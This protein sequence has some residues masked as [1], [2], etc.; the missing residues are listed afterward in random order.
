MNRTIQLAALLL[1]AATTV[2]AAAQTTATGPYYATPSWDQTMPAATRFV[3]LSNFNGEAV[4]DRE[5]G[6]VWAR[7]PNWQPVTSG[8][9]YWL[10][11]SI[12]CAGQSI[13]GRMGWR[14]ATAA[15]LGSLFD[16]AAPFPHLPV[17]HP[18]QLAS[19]NGL[20]AGGDGQAASTSLLWHTSTLVSDGIGG[21]ARQLVF[22][23][24][25]AVF[26][27]FPAMPYI[28]FYDNSNKSANGYG[29]ST[30]YIWCVR[31]PAVSPN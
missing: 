11:S 10:V 15:E 20:Y 26:A 28:N 6:V 18:F 3:V 25:M 7:T 31:A 17:G 8:T 2:G 21:I 19:P 14:L 9:S 16:R 27:G 1:A 22:Q 23:D 5:T 30:E 13:G 24:T 4:L 12:N 29:G